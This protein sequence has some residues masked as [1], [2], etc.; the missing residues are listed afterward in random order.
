[1]ERIT[2][3]DVEAFMASC[4]RSGQSVKSTLNYLGLLH[5]I[6]DFALRRK[7]VSANPCKLVEK[8][9][10]ED[11]DA[12]IRFLDQA[13]LDALLAALPDDDLGRVE[14]SC[15]WRRR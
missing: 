14:R 2:P 10:R 6:F 3:E 8:P 11:A 15:T 9:R 4:R 7:W 5:S 12:D 1:L 13:E